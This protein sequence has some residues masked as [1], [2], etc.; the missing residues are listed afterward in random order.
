MTRFHIPVVSDTVCPWCYVGYRH[1]KRA[2]AQQLANHPEDSF[3]ISW[4]PFQLNP[5]APKGQSIDKTRSYNSKLG[6]EQAGLV[7]ER[8]RSA[9]KDAGID[10]SFHGR[11]GNTLDSHRIIELARQKEVD[12][13][14]N[15]DS[16]GGAVASLQTRVVEEL[17]ADYFERE[18]DITDHVVLARA[19]GRAGMDEHEVKAF[20]ESDRLAKQVEN[21][22]ADARNEG[23]RGVPLFTINDTFEVEGA[24][25][26]RAF[27]M[28]FE[29]LR[30]KQSKM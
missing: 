18:Q 14:A 12:D 9:G 15:V 11:T 7:F 29:R 6:K 22:A 3:V 16:S 10:F 4:R 30:K 2:I 25:E 20:L 13:E 27:T 17:F 26:P 5:T 28:L 24:Q 21:E 23:I 1:L 8:L 19:A